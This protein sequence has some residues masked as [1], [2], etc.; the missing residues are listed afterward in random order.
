MEMVSSEG[1][2]NYVYY[3]KIEEN[4]IYLLL[5]V[6]DMFIA[7]KDENNICEVKCILKSCKDMFIA[8]KDAG[9]VREYWECKY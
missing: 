7:C 4:S 3:K 1:Y 9:P 8:C 5:Y 2:N 6:D